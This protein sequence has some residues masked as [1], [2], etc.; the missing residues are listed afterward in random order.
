MRM[1][2]DGQREIERIHRR[3]FMRICGRPN[4]TI[5]HVEEVPKSC[6]ARKVAYEGS[7]EAFP[8]SDVRVISARS[9]VIA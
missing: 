9:S 5:H 6:F 1:R 3:C 7:V 2:C 4:G 8:P